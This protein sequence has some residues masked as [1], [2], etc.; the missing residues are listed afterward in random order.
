M[1]DIS[2]L[3]KHAEDLLQ[4]PGDG[5]SQEKAAGLVETIEK[6]EGERANTVRVLEETKEI[7]LR[8]KEA[9][10]SH[11][12]EVLGIVTP[13]LTTLVLAGSLVFQGVTFKT[14]ERDKAN[15][16]SQLEQDK[17]NE[18]NHQADLA[19]K[20]R[21]TEALKV[22]S[23]SEKTSPAAALL[24]S[25]TT[26]PYKEYARKEAY[27]LLI[28]RENDASKFRELFNST[29][30]PA[31][32]DSL[33]DILQLN[34]EL[35]E[36]EN[37]LLLKQWDF[38]AG[39]ADP[40]RLQGTEKKNLDRLEAEVSATRSAIVPLLTSKRPANIGLNLKSVGL[41]DCDLSN[42]DL[43]GADIEAANLASVLL[44][45]ANLDNVTSFQT[46]EFSYSPWWHAKRIGPDL[47]NYLKSHFRYDEQEERYKKSK[48]PL[49]EKD[50]EDSIDR[51]A[52]QE[53]R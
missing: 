8:R 16:L 27:T 34:R 46:S 12:K 20:A 15:E 4:Q 37:L 49:N 6:I 40:S 29:L 14:L 44:D 47:L 10:R 45:N 11:W 26:S 43:S 25:F 32:W 50:Y 22:L 53:S 21:W 19:E 7:S 41:G 52:H 2:N 28:G 51:L 23:E 5:A 48:L 42:A 1:I 13:F 39:K 36:Q 9:A 30:L 24:R 33:P 38:R 17:A 31:D 3:R 35:F 18:L